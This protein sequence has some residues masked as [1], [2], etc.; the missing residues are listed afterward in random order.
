M[1]VKADM[2]EKPTAEIEIKGIDEPYYFD[3]LIYRNYEVNELDEE[4]LQS[5]LVNY[6][7]DDYPVDVL[8]GYQDASGYASRT[9]YNGPPAILLK[10]ENNKFKIGYFKAPE[11]FKIAIVTESGKLITSKVINRKM[12]NSQMT[13]DLSGVDLDSSKSNVGIVEEFV[14][15][16][17]IIT[18]FIIRVIATIIIELGI[19]VLFK[20]RLKVSVALV[21]ITNF[22]T[23]SLLTL[24]MFLGYYSWGAMFG[25]ISILIIGE[26]LVFITEIL[27][28]GFLLKEQGKKKACLYGF[29]A[30]LATLIISI[31]TL[32]FI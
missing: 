6:Y 32:S 11:E 5:R 25:L 20:Y 24:F 28:F 26:I 8:N 18:R 31:F 29:V 19:L 7:Q 2:F 15:F 3:I 30:N 10:I 9:L 12:F 4:D 1:N 14:P 13:Y 21:A 23:Q 16:T 17:H 27:T 22:I